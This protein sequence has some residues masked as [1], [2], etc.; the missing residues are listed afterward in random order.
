MEN[1]AKEIFPYCTR[2]GKIPFKVWYEALRD[3]R[4]RSKI[5]IR[6]ERMENGNFGDCS[7]VG[8]GVFEMRINFGPGYRVYFGRDGEKII[9]L[10]CGG[11]KSTQQKDIKRAKAYWIDYNGR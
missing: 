3:I 5:G 6:I 8:D 4:V 1:Q 7:Y 9:I 11:D 10:L 2:N